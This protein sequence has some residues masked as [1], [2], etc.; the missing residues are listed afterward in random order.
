MLAAL[1]LVLA[2]PAIAATL[3]VQTGKWVRLFTPEVENMLGYSVRVDAASVA[4]GGLGRSF[5]EAEV[6]LTARGSY[7]RGSVLYLQRSVDC[8]GNRVV[9]LQWQVTG[10]TGAML[11]GSTGTGAVSRFA[12]DTPDGKIL[13]YVCT[14]A[15][16][17]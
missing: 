8:A 9:T 10:P 17:R 15:L 2:V 12:W 5:R 3:T 14:G 13:K 11:G 4:R 6:L 16:P 1:G 7:P